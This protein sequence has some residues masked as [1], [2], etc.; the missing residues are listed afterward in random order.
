MRMSSADIRRLSLLSDHVDALIAA[1]IDV[2]RRGDGERAVV[3]RCRL[4][5]LALAVPEA[6]WLTPVIPDGSAR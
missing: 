3:E 4:N 5:V 2:G 1:A 6:D